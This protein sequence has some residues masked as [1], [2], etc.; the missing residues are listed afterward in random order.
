MRGVQVMD[1]KIRM[2]ALSCTA[3]LYPKNQGRWPSFSDILENPPM[4]DFL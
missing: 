4:L 1:N 3:V 2:K